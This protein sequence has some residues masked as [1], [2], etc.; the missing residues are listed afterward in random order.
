MAES[1]SKW[2]EQC[3]QKTRKNRGLFGKELRLGQKKKKRHKWDQAYLQ[4]QF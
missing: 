2:L 4:A 3:F 1:L